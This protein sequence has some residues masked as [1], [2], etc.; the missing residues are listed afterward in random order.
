MIF[1]VIVSSY[2]DRECPQPTKSICSCNI[3][4]KTFIYNQIVDNCTLIGTSIGKSLMNSCLPASDYFS[5]GGMH[6]SIPLKAY[7]EVIKKL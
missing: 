6:A 7:D 2:M 1:R 5:I 4:I 3:V